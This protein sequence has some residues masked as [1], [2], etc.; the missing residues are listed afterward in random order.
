MWTICARQMQLPTMLKVRDDDKEAALRA[1]QQA[2]FEQVECNSLKNN[3]DVNKTR[4]LFIRK[5]PPPKK[6]IY[7]KNNDNRNKYFIWV[8]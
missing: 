1:C 5:A 7:K 4:Y 3:K 2:L 6:N 8:N